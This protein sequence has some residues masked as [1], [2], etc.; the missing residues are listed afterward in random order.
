MRMGSRSRCLGDEASP[1]KLKTGWVLSRDSRGKMHGLE[2]PCYKFASS[3][4]PK[5]AASYPASSPPPRR[6]GHFSGTVSDFVGR[7]NSIQCKF[8]IPM[9]Q[10]IE[11]KVRI[12]KETFLVAGKVSFCC[13]GAQVGAGRPEMFVTLI[14]WRPDLSGE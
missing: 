10:C 9:H 8:K 5:S 4:I 2:N 14:P 1:I 13:S 12:K 3:A 6:L 11:K 7:P